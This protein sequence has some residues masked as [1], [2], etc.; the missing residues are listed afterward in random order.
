MKREESSKRMTNRITS[1]V[2]GKALRLLSVF[3]IALALAASALAQNSTLR[4]RVLDERGDAIPE[5]EVKLIGQDGKER[6]TKSGA[7]GDF[8]ISNVPPGAYTLTSSYKG[9]QNQTIA[10]LKSVRG[11]LGVQSGLVATNGKEL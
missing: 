10:D 3:F 7:M 6:K 5:A 1:R 11:D 2:S 4:G 9:F 8:S